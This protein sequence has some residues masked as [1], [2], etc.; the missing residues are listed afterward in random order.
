M[1]TDLRSALYISW[2]SCKARMI[3]SARGVAAGGDFL[4]AGYGLAEIVG[5]E[6]SK[7]IVEAC[8]MRGD[9]AQHSAEAQ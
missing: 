2:P 4:D 7:R 8:G 9:A 3:A 1:Y 6:M 5:G